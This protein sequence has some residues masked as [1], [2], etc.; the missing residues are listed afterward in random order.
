VGEGKEINAEELKEAAE[1]INE[2][3]KKDS[4]NKKVKMAKRELE[5]DYKP[6]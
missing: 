5:R 3:L 4:K 6:R 1:K 2:A